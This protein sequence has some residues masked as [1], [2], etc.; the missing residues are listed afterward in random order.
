MSY[1]KNLKDIFSKVADAVCQGLS[2]G[3]QI[4]VCQGGPEETERVFSKSPEIPEEVLRIAFP[5]QYKV[6]DER[7]ANQIKP[8][9]YHV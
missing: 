9:S 2:L 7:E 5:E 3:G 1:L 6:D 8:D 4:D